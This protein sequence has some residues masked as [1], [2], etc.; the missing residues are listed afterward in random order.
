MNVSRF[1]L[2]QYERSQLNDELYLASSSFIALVSFQVHT[3]HPSKMLAAI[4][5][6]FAIIEQFQQKRPYQLY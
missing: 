5:T 6:F 3:S 4:S 1:L 2:K